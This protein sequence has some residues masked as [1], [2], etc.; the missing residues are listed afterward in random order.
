MLRL[1]TECIL[2]L[3]WVIAFAVG[4][5]YPAPMAHN[6]VGGQRPIVPLLQ[7]A[8]EFYFPDGVYRYCQ[9]S[10][11]SSNEWPTWDLFQVLQG[12]L[13]NGF[14]VLL[15]NLQWLGLLVLNIFINIFLSYEFMGKQIVYFSF[16]FYLTAGSTTFV[17]TECKD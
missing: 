4:K 5:V 14:E 17:S 6:Q 7:L 16:R 12:Y 1:E 8:I 2:I 15:N 10:I 3:S 11:I 9:Q 13:G